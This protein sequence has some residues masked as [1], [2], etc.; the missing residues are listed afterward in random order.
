ME[1]YCEFNKV[2]LIFRVGSIQEYFGFD[3][4]KAKY[5][6]SLYL[7][8]EDEHESRGNMESFPGAHGIYG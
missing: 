7:K 5:F 3:L 8:K 1:S 4:I 2:P 6:Y